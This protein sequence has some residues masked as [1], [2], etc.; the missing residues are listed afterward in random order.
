MSIGRITERGIPQNDE[1]AA[2]SARECLFLGLSRRV[3][4]RFGLNNDHERAHRMV[5][6]TRLLSMKVQS[7]FHHRP[8][9]GY[10]C[11]VTRPE[12]GDFED[13]Y[14]TALSRGVA[15]TPSD[16][17]KVGAETRHH[18]RLCFGASKEPDIRRAV[19]TLGEIVREFHASVLLSGWAVDRVLLTARRRTPEDSA[20]GRPDGD[21]LLHP[22][23]LRCNRSKRSTTRLS[24]SFSTSSTKSAASPANELRRRWWFLLPLWR[25]L[26]SGLAHDTATVARLTATLLA[27]NLLVLY[28]GTFQ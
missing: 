25:H 20:H 21:T 10:C 4:K 13:L 12:E 23:T 15:Y 26:R 7:A 14:R 17:F 6:T 8:Q 3:P 18:M 24:R 2:A 9:G 28:G 19:R 1:P 11:W 5:G 16:V 27:S 22:G